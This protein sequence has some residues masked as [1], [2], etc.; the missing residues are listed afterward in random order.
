MRGPTF[1]R[2]NAGFSA[3]ARSRVSRCVNEA[4]FGVSRR[5]PGKT[6]KW[7]E[8]CSSFANLLRYPRIEQCNANSFKVGNVAGHNRETVNHRRSSDQSI[9][10]R[11]RIRNVKTRA[12]LRH[13]CIDGQNAT[14][15]ARQDLFLDPG[16]EHCALRR[17][18]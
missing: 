12:T 6:R 4:L 11:A 2:T 14:R 5:G 1:R 13:G 15:K 16:A 10:F 3:A 18:L 8:V 7:M 9:A 17:V